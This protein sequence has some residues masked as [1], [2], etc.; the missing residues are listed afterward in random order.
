M[1][2]RNRRALLGAPVMAAECP[3]ARAMLQVAL[4]QDVRE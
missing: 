2:Q 3:D 1:T 4:T